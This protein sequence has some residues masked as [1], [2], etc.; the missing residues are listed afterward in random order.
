MHVKNAF[1]IQLFEPGNDD[2]SSEKSINKMDMLTK[3]SVP[4]E[5][6]M[7]GPEEQ[8]ISKE[9]ENTFI[10]QVCTVAYLMA[11]IAQGSQKRQFNF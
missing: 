11:S 7:K 8:K 3:K 10:L 4:M 2:F 5:L 1:Y 6:L 9:E